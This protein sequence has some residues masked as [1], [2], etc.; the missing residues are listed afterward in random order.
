[1]DLS[2]LLSRKTENES[3]VLSDHSEINIFQL[4]QKGETIPN[5]L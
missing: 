5:L 1:M 3:Q 4:K 2:K